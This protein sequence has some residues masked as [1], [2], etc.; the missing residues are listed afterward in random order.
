MAL[1]MVDVVSTERSIFSGEARFVEVPGAQGELGV[2]PGHTPLLTGV[3]PGTVRIEAADGSET[4]LYIAGGF[5]EIQPDR[6]TVLADTAMRADSLDHARAERAREEAQALL[7][8]QSGDID[9]AKAQA[10]LA[11]AVAQLQAIRRM[12]KQKEVR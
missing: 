4:Y 7:E 8:Q 10:E 12:R 6:V 11:E 3:R 9:Y 5:V 1:L 2:L